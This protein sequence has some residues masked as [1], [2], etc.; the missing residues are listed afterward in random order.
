[1]RHLCFGVAMALLS[2]AAYAQGSSSLSLE[3]KY[4][5]YEVGETVSFTLSNRGTQAVVVAGEVYRV[6]KGGSL[7]YRFVAPF[8]PR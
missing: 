8:S 3:P 4:P 6:T 5:L 1:M 7:V 2:T